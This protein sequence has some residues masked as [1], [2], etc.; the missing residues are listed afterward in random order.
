MAMP[1]GR[2]TQRTLRQCGIGTEEPLRPRPREQ[3]MEEEVTRRAVVRMTLEEWQAWMQ[4]GGEDLPVTTVLGRQCKLR[5][6]Q[7]LE[8]HAAP[9]LAA[10]DMGLG[11]QDVDVDC[12]SE[13]SGELLDTHEL[14]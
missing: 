5:A 8:V 12:R 10:E 6:V 4:V 14:R 13:G 2:C 3:V 11:H 7:L 9:L 1:E